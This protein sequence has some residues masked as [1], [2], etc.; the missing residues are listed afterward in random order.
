MTTFAGGL[1]SPFALAFDSA[2]NLY[3]LT[4]GDGT[5]VELSPAGLPITAITGFPSGGL[6]V[7]GVSD[8]VRRQQ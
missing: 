6:A 8:A 3:V 1:N 2:G 7:T 4:V 5:V